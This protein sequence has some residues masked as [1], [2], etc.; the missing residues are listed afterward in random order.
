MHHTPTSDPGEY[1]FRVKASN[2]DDVWNEEGTSVKIIITPPFWQ[3]LGFIIIAIIFA[4]MLILL[5]YYIR[6][7]QIINRNKLLNE[8][9]IERTKE[10]TTQR[11][12]LNMTNSVKDKLFSIISHDLRSPFN[13]LKGFIE[14]I[15]LKYDGYSDKEIKEMIG[16]ISDSADNVYNL[17]D[18]L[19]NWSRSQ[20]GKSL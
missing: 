19:L 20:R 7:R 9:V 4:V 15:R 13:T 10:L 5:I 17:L 14:L 16:I 12:E 2:N 11:D 1:T 3:T 6:F 8:Q 18:N